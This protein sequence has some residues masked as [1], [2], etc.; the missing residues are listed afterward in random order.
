MAKDYYETL[1]VNKDAGADEIK[2]AYRKLA[3]KYHPDLNKGDEGAAQKFKEVNEAYQVLSD[4]Q[5]RQQYDMYG[6][7]D[8]NGGFGGA[9]QGGFGGGFEGFGGFGDIFENLFGGGGMRQQ[10]AGPQRGGDIRV[11]MRISFEQAADGVKQE[12]T[13]NRL[14]KCDTC[15]GSGAK[16]GTERRTCPTCHGTGQQRV[17]QQTMFGNFVNVQTCSTCNGEGTIADSPCEDCRGRGIKQKQRTIAVNI[18][19]GID[20]GQV[21]TMRGEGNAG[22]NGGPA[23]DLL[24]VISVK[25]HKLFERLGYDLYLDMNISMMQ[26]ALGDE[27]EV[28]VLDG[29]V[30]YQVE[31]G[32]QP[33]TVFRLKGKGIQY[34]NSS[35][36]GDLYVRAN[37]QIP[38]KLNERQKKVLRDFEEKLKG[39]GTET[40]FNKPKDAF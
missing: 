18:P 27:I 29:K 3:K 13:V 34:L 20:N 24:I 32:T 7:A 37:V 21:L 12:V 39:K 26:A 28:P 14:E 33:G 38:K 22:K 2:S 9:G 36:K 30:R 5:K 16:P 11:N 31:P 23:G 15:G 6:N 40:Q 4:D 25:P 19:A 10:K 17:Q 35:R 8:F 1:G